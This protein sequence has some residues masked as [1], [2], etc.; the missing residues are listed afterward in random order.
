MW[1]RRQGLLRPSIKNVSLHQSLCLN[2]AMVCPLACDSKWK[3]N[4]TWKLPLLFLK[5][6]RELLGLKNLE[7][8]V[9][10]QNGGL[11]GEKIGVPRLTLRQTIVWH[12]LWNMAVGKHIGIVSCSSLCY[13]IQKDIFTYSSKEWVTIF[14]WSSCHYARRVRIFLSSSC[15]YTRKGESFEDPF[16]RWSKKASL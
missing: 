5:C 8:T 10:G 6:I 1:C 11:K 15:H 12:D 9:Q 16:R 14:L 2:R 13:F 4:V 3:V 7:H